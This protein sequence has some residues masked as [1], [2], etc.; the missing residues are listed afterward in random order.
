MNL[1]LQT[2]PAFAANIA[3][4]KDPGEYSPAAI[5]KFMKEMDDYIID[6]KGVHPQF[7]ALNTISM[8]QFQNEEE[9][10]FYADAWNRFCDE[11]AKIEARADSG[12]FTGN[13]GMQILAQ[14]LKFRQAAEL[15]K[16]E[17]IAKAMYESVTMHNQQACAAFNFKHS[18]S[19]CVYILVTKYGVS[20]KDIALIWGGGATQVSKEKKEKIALRKKLEGNQSVIDMLRDADIDLIDIGLGNAEEVKQNEFLKD[21]SLKL[22]TQSQE[23]RQRN[24]DRFQRGKANYC[25]FTFKAGGVGLSLHHTDEMTKE[26]VRRHKDSNFA[27]V[28]D[29]PK[30]PSKQRICFLSTTYS[31]MELVQ[32]LGRTSRLT[33]L[34]DTIQII[35]FYAGTIEAR[36]AAI[37][38]TKLRCLRKV[39]RVGE[40]WENVILGGVKEDDYKNESVKIIQQLEDNNVKSKPIE[41]ESAEEIELDL[42]NESE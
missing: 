2:W 15:I 9:Q 32:G 36:V 40:S 37:V 18:I 24:I 19:K 31:A 8:I 26:K 12:S 6:I 20:R 14:F 25:F 28:E 27:F 10:Q 13:S 16:C 30:I 41:D 34:S 39:V 21:D 29:I 3:S 5:E 17:Y 1:T 22:G 35:L 23:E 4:P 11:K 33:S 42:E 38:S 7:R